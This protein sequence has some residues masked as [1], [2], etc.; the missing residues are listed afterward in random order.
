[1]RTRTTLIAAALLAAGWLA[2]VNA[3]DPKPVRV[4]VDNFARAETDTYF[5]KFVKDGALGKCGHQ[6]ELA[7]ID[8]QTVIRMNRDTLYSQALFDL[9]AGPITVTLPDA[10]KRFMAMQVINED[11]Y[12]TEVIYTPGAHTFTREKVG[13]RYVLTL[14]RTFVNPNDAADV[15]AVHALQDAIEVE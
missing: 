13:T 9:D 1:M 7:P 10:G 11:H 3:E 5:A 6:R 2:A 8:R 4:T 12:T 14:V 15:K